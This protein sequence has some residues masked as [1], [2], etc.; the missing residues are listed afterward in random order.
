MDIIE[1]IA[2]E[3]ALSYA[4]PIKHKCINSTVMVFT[5]CFMHISN[6][7]G[8]SNDVIT[9]VKIRKFYKLV[10]ITRV[11]HPAEVNFNSYFSPLL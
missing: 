3:I 8:K 4:G 9:Q 11:H 10:V 1:V 6:T 2:H 7:T 5:I